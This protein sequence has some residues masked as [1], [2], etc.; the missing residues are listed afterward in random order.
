MTAQTQLKM[1]FVR[2]NME[3]WFSNCNVYTDHAV[4][5]SV[6]LKLGLRFCISNRF[7]SDAHAAGLCAIPA[8]EKIGCQPLWST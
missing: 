4:S 5:D 8:E 2:G 7:P 6:C 1:P 3:E